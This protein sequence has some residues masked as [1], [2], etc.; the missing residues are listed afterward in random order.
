MKTE[1]RLKKQYDEEPEEVR[2]YMHDLI[3]QLVSE[4]GVLDPSWSV[5]LDMICD[6]YNVHVQAR[7]DIKTTGVSFMSSRGD[8]R[9]HPSFSAMNT[10]SSQIQKLLSSFAAS[11]YQKSKMKSLDR[12]GAKIYDETNDVK[13]IMEND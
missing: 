4:Y 8:Y 9:P 1:T 7:N 10:S 13:Y 2:E 11:P 5:S 3:D 12:Q 6:W